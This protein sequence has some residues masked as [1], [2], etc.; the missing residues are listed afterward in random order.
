MNIWGLEHPV[1]TKSWTFTI[2]S[3]ASY[4]CKQFLDFK[5]AGIVVNHIYE[6]L[7]VECICIVK[8]YNLLI[9]IGIVLTLLLYHIYILLIGIGTVINI[10]VYHT[11][12]LLIDIEIG[13]GV[14]ISAYHFY[15]LL[16]GNWYWYGYWYCYWY[17]CLPHLWS[18]EGWFQML[19]WVARIHSWPACM[20]S[21]LIFVVIHH[22]SCLSS[23]KV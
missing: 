4:L 10:G 6:L 7:R 12:I 11:Y 19:E 8:S 17:W 22:S 5:L 16:K 15:D 13:I 18:V 1:E 9:G 2:G 14:G 20:T 3:M 23:F 21:L